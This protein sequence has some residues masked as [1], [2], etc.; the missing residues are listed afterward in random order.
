MNRTAIALVAGAAFGVVIGGVG[1]AAAGGGSS[2]D[3]RT[4]ATS[5]T[6]SQDIGEQDAR[7]LRPTGM[8][9]SRQPVDP[10]PTSAPKQT[11]GVG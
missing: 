10:R 8:S 6:L 4:V 7:A 5:R 2:D 9:G 3:D 11:N 1:I